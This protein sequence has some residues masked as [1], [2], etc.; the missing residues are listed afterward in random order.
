MKQQKITPHLWFDTQ[1]EEAA[2]FY[3]SV[4]G[5]NSE[6]TNTTY[7]NDEGQEIHGRSPGSVMTVEFELA[8]YKFIGLNG[9]PQFKFTP[10]ISFFVV[11]ESEAE[12]DKLW[13]QL[14]E[15]GTALM[16]L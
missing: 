15:G 13:Q 12:V 16:E 6:I 1:A 11:S 8:G 5:E 9:G 2:E 4:F 3:V 10:A 7:Y 14:A